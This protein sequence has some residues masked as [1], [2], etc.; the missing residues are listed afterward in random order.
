MGLVFRIHFSAQVSHLVNYRQ[1]AEQSD[2]ILTLCLMEIRTFSFCRLLSCKISRGRNYLCWNTSSFSWSFHN[3]AYRCNCTSSHYTVR[4]KSRNVTIL[5][6]IFFL[7]AQ[8]YFYLHYVSKLSL[9]SRTFSLYLATVCSSAAG[10]RLVTF[11]CPQLSENSPAF[12]EASGT[13]L[14]LQSSC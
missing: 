13:I 10:K 12:L 5:T 7:F 9:T 4:R 6:A 8:H 2:L 11:Y 1:G 14:L 3:K